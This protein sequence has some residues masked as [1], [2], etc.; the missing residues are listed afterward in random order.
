M[1]KK[2]VARFVWKQANIESPKCPS[3]L[4]SPWIRD[5]LCAFAEWN[6]PK[7]PSDL[8]STWNRDLLCA[9]AE[10][11]SP[12]CPSELKSPWNRDLLCAFAEWNSVPMK[13][14]NHH[15]H[16]QT[17]FHIES[18]TIQG[19]RRSH[20]RQQQR[21]FQGTDEKIRAFDQETLKRSQIRLNNLKHLGE[22]F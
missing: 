7:C 14:L 19:T 6:S 9:F 11:N 2:E 22:F 3:H 17:R 4:K 10:W 8:K 12:K 1:Q 16:P 20:P 18:S 15:H 13:C 5:L 21:L